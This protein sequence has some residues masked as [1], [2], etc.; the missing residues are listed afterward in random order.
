MTIKA[1]IRKKEKYQINNLT[2]YLKKPEKEKQMKLRVR[3]NKQRKEKKILGQK[4]NQKREKQQNNDETKSCFLKDNLKIQTIIKT[5]NEKKRKHLNK[6][7]Q[8]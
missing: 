2:L 6:S 4:K 8:K 1:Y 5:N 3:R 7:N